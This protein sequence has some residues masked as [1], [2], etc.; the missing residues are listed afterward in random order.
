VLIEGS[1][2][3]HLKIGG[4]AGGKGERK[5]ELRQ[6]EGKRNKQGKTLTS[7]WQTKGKGIKGKKGKEFHVERE[8]KRQARKGESSGK[9][10]VQ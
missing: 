5:R 1:I 8:K 10:K 2:R 3:K 4:F 9:E 6:K 7:G